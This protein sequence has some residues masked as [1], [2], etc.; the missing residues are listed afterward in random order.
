MENECSPKRGAQGGPCPRGIVQ[1]PD[2]YVDEYCDEHDPSTGGS[3]LVCVQLLE[4][5]CDKCRVSTWLRPWL[6]DN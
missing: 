1:E 4:T 3:K 5:L 2:T 6:T